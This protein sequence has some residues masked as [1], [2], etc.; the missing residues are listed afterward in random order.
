MKSDLNFAMSSI[1]LAMKPV[2]RDDVAD[3]SH[4]LGVQMCTSCGV[5]FLR[6]DSLVLCYPQR[7]YNRV[8]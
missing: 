5:L 6:A 8:G 7:G 3:Q 1:A 4:A 2:R